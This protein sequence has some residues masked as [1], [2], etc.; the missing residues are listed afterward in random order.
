MIILPQDQSMASQAPLYSSALAAA[1]AEL[2]EEQLAVVNFSTGMACVVGVPGSGKTKSLVARIARLAADGLDPQYILAMTFTRAAASEMSTRL[3]ALG[4]HGARVGTIHS[5]S[6][7]IAATDT[8]LLHGRIDEHE[9]LTIEL[10]KL[11]SEQRRKGAIPE[12]GVDFEGV[13]RYIEACKATGICYIDGDPFGLNMLSEQFLRNRAEFWQRLAGVKRDRLVNIYIELERRRASLSLYDFD[14]MQLWAWMKLVSDAETCRRWRERWSLVIVDEAQDSTPIQWDT[15]RLLTGLESCVDGITN[16]SFAPVRDSVAHNLMVGGDS[17]QSI[18]IWRSADPTLFVQY[19]K[20][21]D[22][23]LLLLPRNYRSNQTVCSVATGLVKGREWHLGGDI[24]SARDPNAF[25]PA[26]TI[27]SFRSV[28]E[29]AEAVIE[30]CLELAQDGGLRSCTV[31][32]RLRVGL[33]LMEISCIRRRIKYIKMSSGSFFSSREVRDILAYLRVAACLDPDGRWLRHIINK[34]FRY[35]GTAFITK[36]ATWAQASG[37]SLM[38]GLEQLSDELNYK[39]RHSLKLFYDLLRTLNQ[40]AVAAEKLETD[41]QARAKAVQD[42]LLDPLSPGVAMGASTDDDDERLVQDSALGMDGPDDMIGLVLRKTNYLEELR[43]EEGLLGMDESRIAALAA[44]QRMA[45]F[46]PTVAQFLTYVDAVTVA[47][48]QAAKS[49]LR[50]KEESREDALVLSTIHRCV[51]PDTIM[52]TDCGLLP[53]SIVPGTGVLGYAAGR[54]AYRNKVENPRGKAIKIEVEGGYELVATPEH[55]MM[56]WDGECYAETRVDALQIGQF[57]RLAL[58]QMVPIRRLAKLPAPTSGD[59]RET[60]FCTPGKC[61]GDMAELLGLLVADGT[62]YHSGFRYTK[63][64]RDT[65]KRFAELCWLLFDV[66]LDIVRRSDCNAWDV[67]GNSTF[68]SRWLLSIGGLEPNGKYIPE[69]IL[70]SPLAIQA[71]FLRGLC[72]DGG[73]NVRPA[74]AG[75]LIVDH[76][77]YSSSRP[78]IARV[79]QIMLLRFGI[80]SRRFLSAHGNWRVDMSG[81]NAKR[82]AEQIGCIAKYK[83]RLLKTS[84]YPRERMHSVPISATQRGKLQGRSA[85]VN[86]KTR[87]YLSRATVAEEPALDQSLL[88]FHHARITRLGRCKSPNMCVEVPGVGRFLQNGFDGC[89]CKGLE[90]RHVFLVDVAA[91]RFPCAKSSNPE[92]ELRLLYVAITRAKDTCQISYAGPKDD[93]DPGR[94]RSPF[95]LL[96][97]RELAVLKKGIAK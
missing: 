13:K 18:Y 31:L 58:R 54:A 7:Q 80:I 51:A 95:V 33:D 72:E 82:F 69:C 12:F 30:R 16:C 56:A 2:N 17:S 97:E 44:L 29:E 22:V 49:G 60:A 25:P 45:S 59:V 23:H 28:E 50:L 38:D 39:Q 57:L 42:G 67:T 65:A 88:D 76:Y 77:A 94:I 48:E 14:D 47:V 3:E 11:L 34:P 79:V 62:V 86:A 27:K 83:Q 15:A 96:V 91:G 10:K 1:F 84:A 5:V 74:T 70:R 87:G 40:I 71:R 37:L 61:N 53:I 19:A 93:S 52:E 92:E 6:R 68:L 32:S 4:I 41:R 63:H 20:D 8:G 46:F 75:G 43:R 81:A 21:A 64:D 24:V 26:I 9:K 85:R 55:G 36:A 78:E 90:W 89:N 73:V 35:I 66:N